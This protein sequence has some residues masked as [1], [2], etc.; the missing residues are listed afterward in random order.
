MNLNTRKALPNTCFNGL[1]QG[2]PFSYR[3][4]ICYLPLN[5]DSVS[6]IHAA[7]IVLPSN[8]RSLS[9]SIPRFPPIA[10]C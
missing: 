6:S 4:K 7:R 9:S 5:F 3:D 10:S 2:L 8:D 1:I